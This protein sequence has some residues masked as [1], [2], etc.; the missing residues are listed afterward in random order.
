MRDEPFLACGLSDEVMAIIINELLTFI[1]NKLDVLDELSIVQICASNFT[2]AEIEAGKTILFKECAG[3]ERVVQRK[4]EDK[5]KKN[6]KDIIKLLKE[7]EPSGH[8][9]FVAKDL[10][11]L[12]PV[13]FDHVDVTR[14]LKDLNSMKLELQSIRADSV[15]KVDLLETQT[16]FSSELSTLRIVVEKI[17]KALIAKPHNGPTPRRHVPAISQ[18]PPPLVPQPKPSVN[19]ESP[20]TAS[21]RD[22]IHRAKPASNAAQRT[23]QFSVPPVE[24]SSHSA[25]PSL[26]NTDND[27]FQEVMHRKRIRKNMRGASQSSRIQVSEPRCAIY[28]S[29]A[30]K[31]TTIQDIRDHIKDMNEDCIDCELLSQKREVNFNSFKVTVSG[32]KMKTFLDSKFWPTGLVYRRY[33]ERSIITAEA[34]K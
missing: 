14:L 10:N 21:Y 3:G 20:H 33:R 8:P 32:S 22:I 28:L 18:T 25:Q 29:R 15:S 24:G 23:G 19:C 11:K 7:S 26:S 6:L 2:D 1:Q 5:N 34:N 12:P 30:A 4:G 9:S 17:D 13:N 31:A 16:T 27:G